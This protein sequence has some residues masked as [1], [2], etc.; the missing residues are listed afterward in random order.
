MKG[1]IRF[2][3]CAFGVFC[4][5]AFVIFLCDP[6]AMPWYV[7]LIMAAASLTTAFALEE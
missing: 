6:N 7:C 4:A 5:I 3:F 1:L 2:A